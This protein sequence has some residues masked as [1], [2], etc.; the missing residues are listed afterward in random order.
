[1]LANW[2]LQSVTS[3]GTGDISLGSPNAGYIAV[4]DRYVNGDQFFYTIESGTDKETGIGRYVTSGNKVVR[5]QVLETLISGTFNKNSPSP[6]SVASNAVFF[7]SGSTQ[8][9]TTHDLVWKDITADLIVPP[10]TSVLVP[11]YKEFVVNVNGFHFSPSLKEELGI[12]IRIGNDIAVGKTLYPNIRWSPK[13]NTL[14]TVRWG[15]TLAVAEIN[16]TF[17]DAGVIYLEQAGGGTSNRHQQIELDPSSILAPNPN[18]IIVGKVFR[19]SEH[20]NDTYTGE[21][22]LHSVS[23]NY[24]A[25]RVG[26]PK[27]N[28][29]HYTWG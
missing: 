21:A 3:T 26:T 18:A 14:G 1:M 4:S 11:T 9:L 23:L 10:S 20:V 19:D 6:I 12:K 25:D 5:E 17:S 8:G 13:D 28:A 16:G 15:I 22:V 24:Q 7:I 2:I 27:K 29:N